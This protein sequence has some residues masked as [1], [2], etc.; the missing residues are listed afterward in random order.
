MRIH[1]LSRSISLLAMFLFAACFFPSSQAQSGSNSGTILGTVTDPTGAVVPGAPVTILN[2]VTRYT[3]STVS[4]SAGHYEFKN[5]PFN[6]YHLA[7]KV[8]GFSPFAT[9]V[10]VRASVAQSITNTLQIVSES[11]EITVTAADNLVDDTG[12]RTSIDHADFN[13]LPMESESS[14][15]SS[16]VTAT[17]PGIAADSNGQLHGLGDHASN[18]FSVDGQQ[19]SDQQSKVFSNQLPSNAVQSISVIEGAPPA[20]YGGKT[21]LI[22][23]VTTRSGLGVTKPTG[24]VTTSFGSF[25]SATGSFDI[26][27][28]GKNYGNFFELDG[29]NTGR[30][31]DAPEFSVFHDKGNEVN[32]FD[33]IDRNFTQADSRPPQPQLQPLLVPDPQCLRQ[34]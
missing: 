7:I 15:L 28:G 25:G 16:L 21:S 27:Y 17:T 4:D 10:T 8:P 2:P 24:S 14:G 30:F 20:E 26:S 29:L 33:R 34:P 3:R 5:L 11:T 31:L 18:T 1:A 19:I 32:V 23:Q 22:I 13:K 9:D 12:L 6:A